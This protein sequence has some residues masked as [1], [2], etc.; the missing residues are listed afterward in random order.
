VTHS[1]TCGL[2]LLLVLQ[3]FLIAGTSLRAEI[4]FAASSQPPVV[5]TLDTTESIGGHRPRILGAPQI[6][7]AATG[8]PALLFNGKNDG[9]I[10]PTNPLR[11]F[12]KFTIEILFRPDPNGAPAQRFVHIQDDRDSRVMIETRLIGKQSW[13][14]DTYLHSGDIG[15]P[16]LDRA[17]RHPTGQWA[18]VALVYDGKTM[19]D[20]VNGVK[21]LAGPVDFAPM[22]DGR[23]SL[24]VRLNQVYWFKGSIKEIRFSPAPLNPADLRRIGE[25]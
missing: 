21:E 17:K 24:G 19:S 25:R 22:S 8:G 16:L 12:S 11:G 3:T 15:L 23:M 4:N 20:Y 6:A 9:L 7:S 14:L 10:L 2:Y 5:W 13:S 18:W 1:K